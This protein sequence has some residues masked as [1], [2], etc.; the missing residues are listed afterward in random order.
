M[1]YPTY[2]T[3]ETEAL[4]TGAYLAL[5][6][7]RVDPKQDMDDWGFDG[8]VIGPIKWV[9]TTYAGE[10]KVCLQD[11]DDASILIPIVE[12]CV[13]FDGKYYGD[14]TVYQHTQRRMKD[15]PVPDE[16]RKG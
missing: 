16:R 12:G 9:H 6:H 15:V 13:S 7:G 14:W 5:Y 8:P 3:P 1:T 10:I 2:N 4:P 11:E